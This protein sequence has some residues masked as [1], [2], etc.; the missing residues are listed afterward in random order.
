MSSSLCTVCFD[1]LYCTLL[2]VFEQVNNFLKSW[3]ILSGISGLVNVSCLSQHTTGWSIPTPFLFSHV[4]KHLFITVCFRSG[5]SILAPNNVESSGNHDLKM[6]NNCHFPS[7]NTNPVTYQNP[8]YMNDPLDCTFS[9]PGGAQTN[10]SYDC[11]DDI[12]HTGVWLLQIP[13][14]KLQ[15]AGKTLR[16]AILSRAPHMIRDR[17]YHLKTY[18]YIYLHA[19]SSTCVHLCRTMSMKYLGT[20]SFY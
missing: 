5:I 7:W 11:C 15:R 18:R 1:A 4:F 12:S 17:K 2:L 10:V 8:A 9:A 13:S 14:E 3:W 19:S 20:I 6:R 16:N